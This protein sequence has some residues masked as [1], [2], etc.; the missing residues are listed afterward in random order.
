MPIIHGQ[1][2]GGTF[3]R[4]PSDETLKTAHYTY[5]LKC[6]RCGKI[7]T[8]K[9]PRKNKPVPSY[10]IRVQLHSTDGRWQSSGFRFPTKYEAS[11]YGINQAL[12]HADIKNWKVVSSRDQPNASYPHRRTQPES[13]RPDEV[14]TKRNRELYPQAAPEA[15]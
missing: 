13:K 8:E 2:C 12:L 10:L 9:R 1:K 5:T 14:R 6:N 15:E 3:L 7:R 4:T 11:R